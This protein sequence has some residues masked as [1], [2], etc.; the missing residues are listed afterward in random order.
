ML[1]HLLLLWTSYRGDYASGLLLTLR[2]TGTA[3]ALAMGIGTVAAG[4]R[5]SPIAPLRVVGT[6]YVEV[7]RNIPLMSLILVVAYALPNIDIRLSYSASI[8]AAMSLV[9]GSFVC[10][11]LRTGVNTVD[12]GQVEA[13][14]S[15]GLGFLQVLGN[16]VFPQAFRSMVQP[17]VSILIGIFLSSSLAGVVGQLDLT[18]MSS[19]INNKEALGLLPF[20]V[21]AVVYCAISL[22]VAAA[23]ARVEKLA[24]VVR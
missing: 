12:T 20:A 5:I 17:F 21:A 1:D 2:L 7:F 10:E 9:G 24:R 3:F 19:Q 14:R 15:I 22:L 23:G 18:A 6:L 8:I 4:F 11:A 16:V 13:A